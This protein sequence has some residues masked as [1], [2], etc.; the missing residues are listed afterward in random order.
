MKRLLVL[1]A[2]SLAMA[3]CAQSKGALS[4]GASYPPS[5]VAVTP[6]P[7]LY[8]TINPGMGGKAVAQTALKNPDDPQWAGR[9][10]ASVAA[11]PVPSGP[12]GS[13][14]GQ[15]AVAATT[16]VP[17]GPGPNATA[18]PSL[19]QQPMMAPAAM[20]A[21]AAP[22][23]LPPLAQQSSNAA[24]PSPLVAGPAVPV[25]PGQ[26]PGQP[27]PPAL[28]ALPPDQSA[29]VSGLV[30]ATGP[31]TIA[32]E[33]GG[34]N[35]GPAPAGLP[36]PASAPAAVADVAV[37]PSSSA[38]PAPEP[39]AIAPGPNAPASHSGGDPL[40][41]PN[42]DLMPAMPSLPPVQSAAKPAAPTAVTPPPSMAPPPS[43][44]PPLVAPPLAT[45]PAAMPD[46]TPAPSP[47]I[48]PAP[49]PAPAPGASGPPV[50]LDPPIELEKSGAASKPAN[51]G[52][53]AVELPLE[54]APPSSLD[55]PAASE[56]GQSSP[57]RRG[58]AQVILTSAETPGDGSAKRK[59]RGKGAGLPLARVGDEIITQHDLRTAL[60]EALSKYPMPHENSFDTAE[61][62]EIRHQKEI[63]ARQ[64]FEGLIDR[65]VLVQEAKRHI[66]DKKMLDRA[67]RRP[68]RSG[69]KKR[70]SHSSASTWSTA[71][72]SSGKGSPRR[73]VP[74]MPCVR[75]SGNSS[76]PKPFCARRSGTGST[77]NCPIFSGITTTTYISTNSTDPPRSPGARLW[78]RSTGTRAA[79]RHRRRPIYCSN[80]CAGAKISPGWLEP[81]AKAPPARATTGGLMQ[82]SPGSYAVKPINDALDSLPLGQVST[83]IE[84]PNS[85]HILKVERRRPAGP[86]T[87]EEV[88][89]Q[90]KPM[91]VDKKFQEERQAYLAKIRRNALII[92]Y[93]STNGEP[94]QVP[95]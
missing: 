43:M 83:V 57:S 15:A 91:L 56:P 25:M 52:L 35:A 10:Q 51:A 54:P 21:A 33:P 45:P 48:S 4:R 84:G 5:P 46:A 28:P 27:G 1:S 92:R 95:R 80:A 22:A 47:S 6:V 61:A 23:A 40:L 73:G 26:A 79:R 41:G 44:T 68:T 82:T 31:E 38:M 16:P 67:T 85:F 39:V 37:S 13:P 64:L 63:M 55:R 60:R 53:A 86:A 70:S 30:R 94:A 58:D 36:E 62:M 11:R 76:W 93:A 90:I 88:Q 9:A 65:S 12:P 74:S 42:P 71:R 72:P 87:F 20:A 29:A 34:S 18:P 89:D 69:V 50:P 17:T 7:S 14:E 59:Y 3:G 19:A 66:K 32:A 2:L 75:T 77:S 81:T 8:D 78:S 49:E 24:A